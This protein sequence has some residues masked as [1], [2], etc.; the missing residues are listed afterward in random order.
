MV[1]IQQRACYLILIRSK[2]LKS[3][4]PPCAREEEPCKSNVCV[5]H[6][7]YLHHTLR[8][9]L[10]GLRDSLG[11]RVKPPVVYAVGVPTDPGLPKL[12]AR[13]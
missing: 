10:F 6:S 4:L 9:S 7:P 8:D 13:R 1:T 11:R 5:S 3:L 2:Y 12:A